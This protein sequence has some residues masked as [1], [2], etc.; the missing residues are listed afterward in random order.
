MNERWDREDLL[1]V[2]AMFLV[3]IGGTLLAIWALPILTVM[4]VKGF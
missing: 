4:V 3:L 2:L 1:W